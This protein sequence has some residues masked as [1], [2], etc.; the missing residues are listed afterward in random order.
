MGQSLSRLIEAALLD[1]NTGVMEKIAQEAEGETAEHEKCEEC[2]KAAVAGSKFC[3][4]CA[5]NKARSEE[6][7]S[8]MSE[9][10][11][12]EKTSSARIEKLASAVEFIRDNFLSIQM[13]VGRVKMAADTPADVGPGQG[14]N[15]LETNLK[16][17]TPGE[18]PEGF[19]EAKAKKPAMTVPLEVG[20]SPN[21]AATAIQT[22]A[23]NPPG[24]PGEQPQMIQTG[25]TGG[26]K[27]QAKTASV[28]RIMNAM[29]KSAATDEEIAAIRRE[30]KSGAL[31]GG[32]LGGA[33][34]GAVAG[35]AYGGGLPGVL[36]GGVGGAAGG[37]LGGAAYESD[38]GRR[39]PIARHA[40]PIM[41]L[42]GP[43]GHAGAL[44][45]AHMAG[46]EPEKTAADDQGEDHKTL[47]PRTM[48]ATTPEDKPSGVERPA[49]V[50]SQ[51]KHISSSEAAINMTKREGKEVPKKRMGDILSEPM[52]A[53]STDS[54]LGK[55]LGPQ[56]VNQAGAKIAAAQAR[57]L[58]QKV[59]SQKCTCNNAGS[60]GFCKI[61]SKMDQKHTKQAGALWEAGRNPSTRA[62]SV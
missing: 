21:A 30:R 25:G 31:L 23:N 10:E 61:A 51:E 20:A 12:S 15:A 43:V 42:G 47:A 37:A 9:G 55:A 29:M 11:G 19:G 48:D 14:A 18:A 62:R 7:A 24:G 46:D 28:N 57:V 44:I 41:L 54:T 6:K 59:A 33:A 35:G 27:P 2:G 4:E 56:V 34:H 49:E 1:G 45:G 36:L 58:L 50:T 8:G 40:V 22:D 60:C 39:H 38:W 16:K 17:V 13:P 52:L 26:D 3:K 5:S 32:A 53:A